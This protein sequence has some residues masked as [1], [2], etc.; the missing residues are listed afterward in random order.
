MPVSSVFVAVGKGTGSFLVLEAAATTFG[1]D[2]LFSLVLW[3][4]LPKVQNH[5]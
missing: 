5:G 4:M 2:I 3:C 1:N